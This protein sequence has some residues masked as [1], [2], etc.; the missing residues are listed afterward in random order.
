MVIGRWGIYEV[1]SGRLRA[2]NIFPR[3]K[4]SRLTVAIGFVLR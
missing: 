3:K 4:C 2:L 1:M